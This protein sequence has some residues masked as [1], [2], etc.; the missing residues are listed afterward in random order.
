MMQRQESLTSEVVPCG[1]GKQPKLFRTL[2]RDTFHLECCPCD[3]RTA[4]FTTEPEAAAAW[5]ALNRP[6]EPAA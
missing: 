4:K 1:C 2:G 3:T 6:M 5:A